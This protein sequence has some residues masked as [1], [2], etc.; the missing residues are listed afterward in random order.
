MTETATASTQITDEVKRRQRL[1]AVGQDDRAED[2]ARLM[3]LNYDRVVARHGLP[4]G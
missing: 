1:L 2:L 3:R 4:A